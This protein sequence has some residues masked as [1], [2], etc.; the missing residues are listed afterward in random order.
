MKKFFSGIFV[1][2]VIS[3]QS[4]SAT[5][6]AYDY[7][8]NLGLKGDT[9][10]VKGDRYVLVGATKTY[11]HEHNLLASGTVRFDTLEGYAGSDSYSFQDFKMV[12]KKRI[13]FPN[14]GSNYVSLTIPVEELGL[15]STLC[16]NINV[17]S[18]PTISK[19]ALSQDGRI[20]A[21]VNSTYDTFSKAIVEGVGVTYSWLFYNLTY[22]SVQYERVTTSPSVRI[23]VD[24]GGTYLVSASINDGVY[25]KGVNLGEIRLPRGPGPCDPT[26]THPAD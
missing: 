1:L 21:E 3:S 4:F 12:A 2:L 13:T 10:K 25:S 6:F 16:K 8:S 26:C 18:A 20:Y 9:S 19:K 11:E 15:N 23:S 22:P 17:Q 5:P 7:C 14:R 24:Y